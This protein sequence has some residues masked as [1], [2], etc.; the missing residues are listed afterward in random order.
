MGGVIK[1]VEKAV[2]QTVKFAEELVVGLAKTVFA[3]SRID[4]LLTKPDQYLK[5]V[6]IETFKMFAEPIA[7]YTGREFAYEFVY[8]AAI[9]AALVAAW[10]IGPEISSAIDYVAA[11]A[12]ES[13][14]TYITSAA[15]ATAVY[16]TMTAAAMVTTA[17]LTSFLTTGAIY[18]VSESYF[19]AY[20]GAQE[21][22]KA[23][24]FKRFSEMDFSSSLLDGSIY[25]WMAGGL[26]LN[27]VMPGGDIANGAYPNDPYT[28]GLMYESKGS[29]ISAGVSMAL[30][31]DNLAGGDMF[32]LNGSGGTPYHPLFINV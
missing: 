2:K 9:T 23:V 31:Y 25:E 11:L 1:A 19:A 32:A 16:Y 6:G 21:M 5:N 8:W 10:Y 18:G 13:M 12:M 22:F 17:F 26:A 20:Y 24:E 7:A 27:A 30:P 29:D 3:L 28:R 14:A 4:L 15:V